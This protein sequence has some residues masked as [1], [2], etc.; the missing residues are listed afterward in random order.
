[1]T[2]GDFNGDGMADLATANVT[3]NN[4]SVLLNT[5]TAPNEPPVANDDDYEVDEDGTLIVNSNDGV[6]ANDND[7]DMDPLSVLPV[8]SVPSN[9]TLTLNA[10]GSFT[11]IPFAH[12]NGTDSFTYEVSDGK[13]G[14]A[15]A[16]VTINVLSTQQQIDNA[17][18]DVDA[19]VAAGILNNGQGDSLTSKLDNAINKFD[20]GQTNAGINQLEALINQLEAFINAG[21]LDDDEGEDLI[22]QILSA[23]ASAS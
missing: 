14:F 22:N 23:I 2:V 18:S 3:S 13:G 7:P 1:M 6:L 12:F 11:Y 17:I 20:Q 4:V 15:T 16:I 21:I 19:L 10:D 8:I 9:G 5:S